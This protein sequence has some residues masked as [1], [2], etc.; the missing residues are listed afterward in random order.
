MIMQMKYKRIRTKTNGCI[1][2]E[3]ELKKKEKHERMRCNALNKIKIRKDSIKR[4]ENH[5]KSNDNNGN[6]HKTRLK[7]DKNNK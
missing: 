6:V 4:F 1:E 3:M 7:N 2:E 5:N